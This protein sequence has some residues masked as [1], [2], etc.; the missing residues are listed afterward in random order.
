LRR[1]ALELLNSPDSD[2]VRRSIAVLAVVGTADDVPALR[3]AGALGGALEGDGRVAINE[4]ENRAAAGRDPL[5][6]LEG[7]SLRKRVVYAGVGLLGAGSILL[8]A[9]GIVRGL[10]HPTILHL[11]FL[12]RG[13]SVIGFGCWLVWIARRGKWPHEP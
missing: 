8:G 11:P 6:A 4:I 7:P 13:L 2:Q 9:T 5:Q 12:L 3:R 1:A 10:L